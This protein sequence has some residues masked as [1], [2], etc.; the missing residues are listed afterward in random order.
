M[1]DGDEVEVCLTHFGGAASWVRA[2]VLSVD[3]RRKI[4]RVELADARSVR[5]AVALSNVR[6]VPS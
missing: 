1:T 3:P 4:A 2:R 5:F 6:A